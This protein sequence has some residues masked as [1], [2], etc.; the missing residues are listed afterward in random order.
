MVPADL[1]LVNSFLEGGSD[2]FLEEGNV[3]MI[4]LARRQ[5]RVRALPEAF[6]S[7]LQNHVMPLAQRDS[8]QRFRARIAQDEGAQASACSCFGDQAAVVLESLVGLLAAQ[9]V[10]PAPGPP[11]AATVLSMPLPQPIASTAAASCDGVTTVMT[12]W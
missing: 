8:S 12:L 1:T 3:E 5:F 2:A 11:G 7:A 4:E 10:L 9:S 6:H